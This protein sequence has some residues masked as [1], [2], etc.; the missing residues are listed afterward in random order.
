MRLPGFITGR[1][2]DGGP[3]EPKGSWGLFASHIDEYMY[4]WVLKT[5]LFTLRLHNIKR[6]DRDPHHHDHPFDFTSIMLTGGYEEEVQDE[7][8]GE[9]HRTWYYRGAIRKLRARDMH[10]LHTVLPSTYTLVISGPKTKDWG[11]QV[12]EEWVHHR[13]YHS[14]GR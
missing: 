8:T 1:R 7:Q 14:L 13:N 12:G 9:L 11:F 10:R 4:R 5:P 6:E 2:K 3:W